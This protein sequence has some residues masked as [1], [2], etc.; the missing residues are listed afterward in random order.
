MGDE[1]RSTLTACVNPLSP[2]NL[3]VN[4][5]EPTQG[6][7]LELKARALKEPCVW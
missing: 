1:I 6:K 3:C 2:S 7:D 5:V 4:D